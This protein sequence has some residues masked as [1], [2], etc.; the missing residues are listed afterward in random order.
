VE[1]DF[2]GGPLGV[3]LNDT[4]YLDNVAGDNGRNPAWSLVFLQACPPNLGVPIPQ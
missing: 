3:W 1:F 4:P 2:D